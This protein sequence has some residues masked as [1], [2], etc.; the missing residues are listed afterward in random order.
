M[1]ARLGQGGRAQ[2]LNL[3]NVKIWQEGWTLTDWATD[4]DTFSAIIS[5]AHNQQ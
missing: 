1:T 3:R 4:G 5:A 2:P